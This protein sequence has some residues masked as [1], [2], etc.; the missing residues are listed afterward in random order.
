MRVPVWVCVGLGTCCADTRFCHSF[1]KPFPIVN[2][3]TI[4][5]QA[6]GRGHI[7]RAKH[8]RIRKAREEQ[9]AAAMAKATQRKRLYLKKKGE[10]SGTAAK[11]GGSTNSRLARLHALRARKAAHSADAA[12]TAAA[13]PAKGAGPPQPPTGAPPANAKRIPGTPKSGTGEDAPAAPAVPP[14]AATAAED[15]DSD[16]DEGEWTEL[17]DPDTGAKYWYNALTGETTWDEPAAVKRAAEA[18]AGAAAGAAGN[19]GDATTAG[20]WIEVVDDDSGDVYYVN[21]ETQESSWEKPADFGATP[22]RAV[23]VCHS[24]VRSPKLHC[25]CV[26]CGVGSLSGKAKKNPNAP[27]IE[28]VDPDSGE[29]YY[30][31]EETEESSWDKPEGWVDVDADEASG[32]T[33]ADAAPQSHNGWVAVLDDDSGDTYYVHEVCH[34]TCLLCHGTC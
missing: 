20:P 4:K 14:A 13:G 32:E 18:A 23:V 25:L 16:E 26:R 31:N 21:T 12:D 19:D 22:A 9:E 6:V 30:V 15:E 5:I 33:K 24:V 1:G 8:R 3:A 34:C 11:T 10:H 29:T 7:A 2:K 28:A 27:W 17:A